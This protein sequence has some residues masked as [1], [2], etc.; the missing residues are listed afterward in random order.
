[1]SL[2]SSI[3]RLSASS[4]LLA[5]GVFAMAGFS[6]AAKADDDSQICT[7]VG[8]THM[9]Y[10]NDIQT[11]I[12]DVDKDSPG[13]II[14]DAA[15]FNLG[16]VYSTT[17]CGKTSPAYITTTSPLPVIGDGTDGG[18]W[19]Q[20][21][22]YL[23]VAMQGWIA[24]NVNNYFPVPFIS[25][26]NKLF[27]SEQHR[28][29]SGSKGKVSIQILKP[30]IGFSPF[31]KVIMQTQ[32]SRNP[33]TGASGPYVSQL[34]MSGQ[35]IVPQN[36]ELDEGKTVEMNFGNIGATAFSEAGAGNKP[37]GVN[38]QTRTIGIKCKNID[39]Q[40]LLSLRL[41]ANNVSGNAMVSDNADI[42]F[43]VADKNKKPLTP[44]DI[45]STIP[46]KLDD[47]A[48]YQLPITAWPVSVTGNKPAEGTFTAEGYLRVDFQ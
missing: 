33:T 36:C 15:S 13:T 3:T 8:G 46:F 25:R 44:N 1:M 10:A 2:I 45:N 29:E 31:S 26:S 35:V 41:E 7:P 39:A 43:I 4:R 32:I 48:S 34:V 18:K 22:E 19:Y 38:P 20:V 47:N 11:V 14:K 27:D 9:Y 24:G 40:A 37:A 5:I 16:G 23:G 42:G 12:T 30:F 17:G 6:V 28:W 21:N